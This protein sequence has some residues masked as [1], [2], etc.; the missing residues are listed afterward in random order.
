MA[1]EQPKGR[2][3]DLVVVGGLLAIALIALPWVL[4]LLSP[5]ETPSTDPFAALGSEP[6]ADYIG[7]QSCQDCHPGAFAFYTNSGH[8]RTIRP[9]HRR[10][11]ARQLDGRSIADPEKPGVT[12]DYLLRDG[13]LLVGRSEGGASDRV[14]VDFALGSGHHATTF[15]TL[16]DASPARPRA[17][18]HRLTHFTRGDLLDITPGQRADSGL[19]RGGP[20][21]Y[22]MTAEETLKCLGCHTTETARPSDLPGLST[23]MPNVSCER[24]HG[25]ARSHVEAALRGDEDDLLAMPFGLDS[26]TAEEQMALC[27]E[28]HRHPSNAA[29]GLI[30]PDNIHLARFQPVG[31]MQSRCYTESEGAF[32]CVTC[33][34]PHDRAKSEPAFYEAACLGCHGSPASAPS[35]IPVDP[36][37]CLECHM[38]AVDSGQG[39]LF[40]DHWI[41]VRDNP[42]DNRPCS[43][44]P[45]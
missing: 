12:W 45:S 8:A 4:A 31:I 34:D 37:G 42:S 9:A 17:L 20:L 14:P 21:G 43:R 35:P 44:P 38:P 25:P 18:E 26:W 29:P 3:S 13:R 30:R 39:V 11:L 28:C 6:G 5:S 22:E 1:A 24:C 33:H 15:L 23:M 41:R 40:T 2:I 32:S 36:V 7:P 16:T 19:D 10:R 27:G